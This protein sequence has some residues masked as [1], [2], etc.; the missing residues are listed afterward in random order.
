MKQMEHIP[1]IQSSP[2]RRPGRG[3]GFAPMIVKS[4]APAFA[5]VTVFVV[6]GFGRYKRRSP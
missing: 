3:F 5:G 2:R 4:T 6:A 1:D